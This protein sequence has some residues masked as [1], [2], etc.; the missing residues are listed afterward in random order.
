MEQAVDSIYENASV[1]QWKNVSRRW[2]P[3]AVD[4][5]C[6][7]CARVVTFVPGS[8]SFDAARDTMAGT[9]ACPGCKETVHF[10]LVGPGDAADASQQGKGRLIMHPAPQMP[11]LPIQ[12]M[13]LVPEAVATAYREAL[14]VYNAQVWNGTAVLLRRTLEGII[15]NL[16]PEN[17]RGGALASMLAKLPANVDLGR[18][19]TTLSTAV[20]QGG[21][22]GAHF[23]DERSTDQA[24]ATQ[25]LSLVEYLLEYLYVLPRAIEALDARLST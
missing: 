4:A 14:E 24:M 7:Y 10:W 8:C 20:R 13:D 3:A 18:P 17:E 23:D 19:I 6:P 9:A 22:I 15:N 12:R 5:Y 1:P 16:L 21:N 2:F 25:M 11:R